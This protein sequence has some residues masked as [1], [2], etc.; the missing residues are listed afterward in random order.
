MRRSLSLL[1]PS[2]LL[3]LAATVALASDRPSASPDT[4]DDGELHNVLVDGQRVT[5]YTSD[6]LIV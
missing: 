6:G 1:A 5:T 4:Y 2:V 3:G